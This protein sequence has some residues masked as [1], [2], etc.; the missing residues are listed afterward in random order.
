MWK[1]VCAREEEINKIV[2]FL[3]VDRFFVIFLIYSIE[4][5]LVIKKKKVK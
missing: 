3:W 1:C 5:V 4:V 2:M